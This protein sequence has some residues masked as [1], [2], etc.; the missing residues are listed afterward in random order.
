MTKPLIIYLAGPY[1]DADDESNEWRDEITKKL[2]VVAQ[3]C[4]QPIKIINPVKYFSFIK[5]NYNSNKQ[6]KNF[7][8]NKILHSDLV[9]CNVDYTAK[10]PRTAQEIQYAYD[11][12]IPIIGY[13]TKDCCPWIAEVDCQVV[14]ESMHE[15][16]D[17]V[18]DYYLTS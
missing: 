8:F 10:S 1:E 4:D 9:A 13:G 2:E 6:V 15:A 5:K 7:Y 17:Y 11:N 3:W 18:R 12:N 16:V 14:F